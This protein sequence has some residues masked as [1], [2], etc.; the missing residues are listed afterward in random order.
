MKSE[1]SFELRWMNNLHNF[2]RQTDYV[3]LLT[4]NEEYL[5]LILGKHFS[6][7]LFFF[8]V[9]VKSQFC[10]EADKTLRDQISPEMMLK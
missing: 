5:F 10:F 8:N 7:S 9:F 4:F 2:K 1:K 3:N 6:N